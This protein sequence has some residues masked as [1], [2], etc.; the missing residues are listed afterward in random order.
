MG[1]SERSARAIE[2]LIYR[3]A[4]LMDAGDFAGV[5]ALFEGAVYGADGAPPLSG[6]A[7]LEA[8]LCKMVRLY[9]GRPA[10]Q[11]VT[12]NVAIEF[13]ADASDATATSCFTVFQA[14]PDFPLQVIVAGRYRDRFVEAGGVWRFSE[15]KVSMDLFGDLSRHLGAHFARSR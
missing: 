15:R 3:Y 11:H 9:D 13:A 5:A 14:L 12:T 10:T 6:R 1:G 7:E 2:N 8:A 4:E